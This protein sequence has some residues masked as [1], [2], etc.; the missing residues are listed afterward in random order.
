MGPLHELLATPDAVR[1]TTPTL[2]RPTLEKVLEV[3]RR[4]VPADK[5]QVDTPT[6][7]LENYFLNVVNKARAQDEV[8]SGATSGHRVA[9]YLR[10]GI[11]EPTAKRERILDRL[12]QAEVKPEPTAP[13]PIV[14]VTDVESLQNK[15]LEQLTRHE[16]PLAPASV[17]PAE[18]KKAAELEKANEK[19]SSLVNKK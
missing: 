15:K 18:P 7:N 4:D 14:T 1:I 11:E 2:A 13:A 6:Q 12:S 19:L 5:V 16:E 17:A 9:E 8:T 3:I 10:G